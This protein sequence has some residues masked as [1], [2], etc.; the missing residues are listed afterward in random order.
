MP[1]E[2]EI[3]QQRELEAMQAINRELTRMLEAVPGHSD[4][5][6][7]EMF[8]SILAATSPDELDKPWNGNGM[9]DY[10]NQ[11][12]VIMDV[13]KEVSDIADG[14]GFFL[15]CPGAVVATGQAVTFITSSVQEMAQILVAY[16][17]GWLPWE[18]V[19]RIATK[20][21]AKGYYPR[22][23]ETWREGVTALETG[24][25]P[26]PGPAPAPGYKPGDNLKAARERSAAARP[27]TAAPAAAPDDE[28]GF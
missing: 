7:L 3:R 2:L 10:I 25:R 28:P 19:P 21:T 26:G 4:Q 15:V 24:D 20:P 13:H 8:M 23:L 16:T 18:C 12:I 5:A 9:A 6:G 22:H 11:R 14:P 27:A 17:N 1:S